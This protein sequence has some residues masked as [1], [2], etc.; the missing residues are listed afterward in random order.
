[1][2]CM[3]HR[4]G[5]LLDIISCLHPMKLRES[6]TM[7]RSITKVTIH[8]EPLRE[9]STKVRSI[10][11]TKCCTLRKATGLMPA[12]S[13]RRRLQKSSVSTPSF[14]QNDIEAAN[15]LKYEC[16]RDVVMVR[17][18][19]LRFPRIVLRT[20][21]LGLHFDQVTLNCVEGARCV[22][23]AVPSPLS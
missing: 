14:G 23:D 2:E 22:S 11:K 13:K 15:S 3:S 7:V 5:C 12:E 20:E 17:Y 10:T 1:M 6:T 19:L 21:F 16:L 4:F 8:W 9:S 18:L